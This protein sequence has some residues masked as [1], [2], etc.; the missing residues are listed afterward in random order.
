ML[1]RNRSRELV[2]LLSDVEKIRSERRKA[3]ANKNKYIGVGNDGFGGS[4]DSGYSGFGNES[5]G[6]GSY[7]GNYSNGMPNPYPFSCQVLIKSSIDHVSGGSSSR[8]AGTSSFSDNRRGYE[9][10]NA[11]DDEVT[12][13]SSPTRATSGRNVVRKS[14]IPPKRTPA[15]VSAPAPSEPLVDLLG[16]FDDD[17]FGASVPSPGANK[18]LPSVGL[19]GMFHFN[20]STK[21]WELIDFVILLLDDDF[22]DFQA[23]PV[24]AP[25]TSGATAPQPTTG[26]KKPNLMDMLNTTSVQTPVQVGY[27]QPQQPAGFGGMGMG[28]GMGGGGIN[29]MGGHSSISSNPLGSQF[30]SPMPP[31]LQPQQSSLFGSGAAP[32]RPTSTPMGGSQSSIS[33]SSAKPPAAAQTKSA[34]FDDLWSMSLGGGGGVS[35]S[36]AKPGAKTAGKSIKDLEKEKA[37]AG[38]W[39][40]QQKPVGGGA[41]VPAAFGGGFGNAAPPSS[42]GDDLLL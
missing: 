20:N 18:E 4:F 29:T 23:A 34:N 22:T 38:I 19:D 27:G 26:G 13:S 12:Q 25:A 6:G 8:G 9:E 5:I 15:P 40:A 24:Q 39:G 35:S 2:E 7:S 1:V 28:M 32:M 10:Y 14:S 36:S 3:K 17:T 16:G 41:P 21:S 33:N 11:G 31:Q 30:S 37:Q 42:G